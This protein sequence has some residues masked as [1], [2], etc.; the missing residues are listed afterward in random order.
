MIRVYISSCNPKES[1]QSPLNPHRRKISFRLGLEAYLAITPL[2]L[3]LPTLPWFILLP[4]VSEVHL[5][6]Y[7]IELLA[8]SAACCLSTL[9]GRHTT[10]AAEERGR[11]QLGATRPFPHGS[12]SLA[13]RQ[14]QKSLTVRP[15]SHGSTPPDRRPLRSRCRQAQ[16]PALHTCRGE[17]A[18]P[19]G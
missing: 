9:P 10:A 11:L 5:N 1:R 8:H 2:F 6:S 18:C 13:V 3:T 17:I 4:L 14:R 15:T 7:G 12:L 19:V 16:G